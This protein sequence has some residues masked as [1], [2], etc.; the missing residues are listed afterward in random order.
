MGETMSLMK[1]GKNNI[2]V[3]ILEPIKYYFQIH[4]N[5]D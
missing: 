2:R 3:A 5:L 1:E 4:Y